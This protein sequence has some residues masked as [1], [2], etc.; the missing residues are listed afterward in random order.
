MGPKIILVETI[1]LLN[2]SFWILFYFR[3]LANQDL[4][5]IFGF[6]EYFIYNFL[7]EFFWVMNYFNDL[8]LI[9]RVLVLQVFNPFNFSF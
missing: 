3:I 1:V 5:L 7:W 2:V 8:V 4:E 9:V 6:S